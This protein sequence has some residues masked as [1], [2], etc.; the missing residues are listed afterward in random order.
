MSAI[1]KGIIPKCVL[2]AHD[3]FGRK[4]VIK[5]YNGRKEYLEGIKRG[6]CVRCLRVR[7][8]LEE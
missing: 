3:C 4:A 1:I 8:K 7:K 5:T 6:L 2:C